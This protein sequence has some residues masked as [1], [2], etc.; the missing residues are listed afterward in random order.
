[1]A[2]AAIFIGWGAAVTGREQQAN[3]VFGEAIQFLGSLQQKGQIESF[4]PLQLEPHGG[5]LAGCCIVRGDRAKLS[6]L[7]FS[8]EFQRI[9]AKAALV[10]EHFGVVDAHIGE[11]LQQVFDRFGKL[12]SELG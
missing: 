1:M 7:R 4:E 10:V 3:Q 2:N 5:D 6:S 12:A 8:E 9:N 11:D